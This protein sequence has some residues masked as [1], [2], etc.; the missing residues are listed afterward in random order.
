MGFIAPRSPDFDISEWR[1]RPLLRR[2]HPLVVDWVENGF[3]SPYSVYLL[4]IVKMLAYA[5]GAI[6]IAATTPGLGTISDF[7]SWWTEPIFYQKVVVFTLLFEVLGFGCASGPLT[8][9]FLPPVGAFMYWLRPGTMRLPPWPGRVPLTAGTRRSLVDVVLYLGVIAAAVWLLVSPGAEPIPG[10]S[11]VGMIDPMRLIPLV[12][13]LPV[14]GLRD[15]TIFL[16]AR[17]EQYWVPLLIF[18]FPF[19]DM[20]IGLKLLMVAIW[21][22]AATSKLNRHFPFVVS[23]MITNSPLQRVKWFKRKLFKNFPTD[24]RP[25]RVVATLAHTGTV[26]EYSVPLVLLFSHGGWPTTIALAIMVIFHLHIIST[27]PLGVPLE[28]NVYVIFGALFLFG[29]YAE[30]S[31]LDLGSPLLGAILLVCLVAG[32]AIGNTK[33]HLASFLV[34]MRYYAGNWATSMWAFRKGSEAKIDEHV[35]KSSRLQKTQ[36]TTLYGE[37]MAELL[38]QKAV[39]F[40]SM[41]HHGR[42]LLGLLPRAVED[43][44]GDYDIREG[45]FVAGTVLGW[46]FG[47]GHL[48]DDR[49]VAALQQRCGFA[50]GEVRVVFLE[51][52]PIQT[53][54]QRYKI[55]DAALGVIEEGW[56]SVKDMCDR[57]PWLDDDGGIPAHVTWRRDLRRDATV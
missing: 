21:W 48:H 8:F 15:K 26:I 17:A 31:V 44:L 20:L 38:M 56:V 1:T 25:S 7:G 16:A 4:Y 24:I 18:F 37:E 2:I 22:G 23:V 55:I 47:E 19:G 5:F 3:G 28:W 54:R 49:F 34:S 57:Q 42:A 41:H 12:V 9:R 32:P 53:Q 11:D 27:F 13:L 50:P 46:N 51:S 40:R 10:V 39:V 14:L 29:H 52:Q 45:E 35:V 30:I 43:D 6:A 33:P 36:L